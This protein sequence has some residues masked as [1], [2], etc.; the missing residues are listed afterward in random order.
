MLILLESRSSLNV[1][2]I[3]FPADTTSDAVV[4]GAVVS[5]VI[6]TAVLDELAGYNV[7]VIL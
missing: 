5:T 7:I 4:D 2:T 6:V 1:I 3:L